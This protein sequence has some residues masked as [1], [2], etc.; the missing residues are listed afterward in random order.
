MVLSKGFSIVEMLIALVVSV[1][2]L[3]IMVTSFA[4]AVKF[5]SQT[6]TLVK[7]TNVAASAAVNLWQKES[8]ADFSKTSDVFQRIAS[9]DSQI[10]IDFSQ[11][12][13]V[14]EVTSIYESSRQRFYVSPKENWSWK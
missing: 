10:A 8:T 2:V 14:H 6:Y 12:L 11:T 13:N 9:I 7:D 1:F 4:Y 5:T 3:L